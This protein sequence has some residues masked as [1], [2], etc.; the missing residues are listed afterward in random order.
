MVKVEFYSN[1]EFDINE[2]K[3]ILSVMENQETTDRYIDTCVHINGNYAEL[4]ITFD[5]NG[6]M[7]VY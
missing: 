1:R 2:I 3:E 6:N 5:E 4:D 7:H